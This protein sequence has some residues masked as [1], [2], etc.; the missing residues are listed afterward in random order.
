MRRNC[1]LLLLLPCVLALAAC[2]TGEPVERES[3]PDNEQIAN[4]LGCAADEVAICVDINCE[5]D[6]YVC[7]EKGEMRRLFEPR[8]PR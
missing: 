1:K 3:R 5:P 2:A 6:D 4:E 8:I 7:A